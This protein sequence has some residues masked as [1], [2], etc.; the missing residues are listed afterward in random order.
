MKCEYCKIEMDPVGH[1]SGLCNGWRCP[2][3]GHEEPEMGSYALEGRPEGDLSCYCNN[4]N[5][6][7]GITKKFKKGDRVRFLFAKFTHFDV[8]GYCENEKMV[9]VIG[10]SGEEVINQDFLEKVRR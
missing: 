9:K 8:V 3:C 2:K 6:K 7:Y 1:S 5:N 10:E 4:C